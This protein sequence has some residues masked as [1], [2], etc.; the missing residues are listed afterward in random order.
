MSGFRLVHGLPASQIDRAAAL[1]WQ[2]FGPELGRVLGPEP[3]GRAY[4]RAVIVPRNALVALDP[5]GRL[6]GF[7]GYTTRLGGF[8]RGGPDE[9][10]AVYGR[11]GG[12]W[13]LAALRGLE[14]EYAEDA[15]AVDG[16]CVAEEA[17]GQGVGQALL[18][19]LEAEAVR[20]GCASLRLEV[21]LHN[22]RAEALY[23]RFGFEPLAA[24]RPGPLHRL[25]GFHPARAMRYPLG[26]ENGAQDAGSRRIA[27]N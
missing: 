12:V 6:L 22:P 27:A 16:I 10:R 3:R 14:R 23:R 24:R 8:V 17:R 5:A 18:R 25:L 2:A 15:L 11:V 20:H 4:F 9:L 13:R 19:G 26:R 1:F 7:A 21:S